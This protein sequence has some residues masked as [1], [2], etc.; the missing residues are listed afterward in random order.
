MT[1]YTYSVPVL[2]I[3][4]YGTIFGARTGELQFVVNDDGQTFSYQTLATD[5]LLD[6]V[7]IEKQDLLAIN[8]DGDNLL[9][10][11][12]ASG[13]ETFFEVSWDSNRN[14]AFVYTL[15]ELESYYSAEVYFFAAGGT[16]L[17]TMNSASTANYFFDYRISDADG[18]PAGEAFGPGSAI[19]FGSAPGVRI[20]ED[21]V[22]EASLLFGPEVIR[23]GVG[24]DTISAN[25]LTLQTIDG[26]EGTDTF[27]LRGYML[28]DLELEVTD[29]A[30]RISDGVSW[31]TVRNVEHFEFSGLWGGTQTYTS[32][33][34][35]FIATRDEVV[36]AIGDELG[37]SLAGGNNHD[38]LE[39]LAG[40]D[41][42]NGQDGDDSLFGGAGDDSLAGGDGDDSL[43]GGSGADTLRGGNGE[44][45][46]VGG[47]GRDLVWLGGG[48]DLFI[49]NGQGG[50]YGRDTVYGNGGND[51]FRGGNGDDR[52]DGQNGH[53]LMIGRLGNDKL[54]GGNQNDT[55]I[56][57]D[58]NDT[59][60]G[61][62]G[63]DRAFMGN[64][65]DIW[66]DNSQVE[67]G[68][69]FVA[70]G[71]GDDAFHIG[72][73]DDTISGGAG[74]DTFLFTGTVNDDIVT[75]YE[76]GVDA[77][78]F[79]ADLWRG[80]L[81]QAHLDALASV[82]DGDLVLNFGGGNSLTLVGLTGTD[83][84]LADISLI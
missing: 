2:R 1:T 50:P 41:R 57:G 52:F 81:D 21:D 8:A 24:N 44:D 12:L 31:M 32:E 37:N 74:A 71:A 40:N 60:A 18:V 26:G 28:E 25:G 30:V 19:R 7:S 65:N 11:G 64:G 43:N 67:F 48:N 29:Q 5:T 49:D 22:I 68:D 6:V 77:L 59:I 62:N 20:T 75:D 46:V 61:G 33:E 10:T 66:W 4:Q 63:R 84:L 39:G 56:G 55:L 27:S 13:Q 80:A 47:D 23:A 34:L 9:S 53:D 82:V 35:W 76:I 58:G 78:G 69:D 79:G 72:G 54:F 38:R 16:A 73:G 14:T 83:G 3:N 42:L 15:A 45:T 70:G 51:T 36:N 17:P